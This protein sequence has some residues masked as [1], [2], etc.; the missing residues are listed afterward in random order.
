MIIAFE[1]VFPVLAG[2]LGDFQATK[3]DWEERNAYFFLS[4]MVEFVC[5]RSYPGFPEYE[6]VMRQFSELLERL[7]N[8][9]DRNVNDLAHDA[10][11]SVWEREER[12]ELAKHFGPKTQKLWERICAGERG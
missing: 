9:G 10:L 11:E 7:I 12:A 3:E 6:I 1:D 8:E 2:A 4:D 5:D